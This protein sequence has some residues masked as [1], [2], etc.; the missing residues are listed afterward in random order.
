MAPTSPRRSV[1][2][3][4]CLR[5]CLKPHYKHV[6]RRLSHHS[7]VFIKTDMSERLGF[8]QRCANTWLIKAA[9][10]HTGTGRLDEAELNGFRREQ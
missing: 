1:T 2:I 10:G 7:S 6:F 5:G 9:A 3:R 8:S 4:A